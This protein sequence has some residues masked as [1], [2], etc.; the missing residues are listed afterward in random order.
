MASKTKSQKFELDG[1]PL[2]LD[3]VNTLDDRPMP[4]A[5]ELHETYEDL[6]QRSFQS[7]AL[8]HR[9]NSSRR[10]VARARPTAAWRSL[11]QARRLRE[12][13]FALFSGPPKSG[14]LITRELRRAY[15]SPLLRRSQGGGTLQFRDDVGALNGMFGAIVRSTAELLASEALSRFRV[16]TLQTCERLLLDES[17]NR[18][19]QW[20]NMAVCGN[21]A[22]AQHYY[23]RRKDGR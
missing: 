6:L 22:K 23:Q 20:C 7:G 9:S 16:C 5:K 21:H 10:G 1:G 14:A 13:L 3:F 18:P 15:R 17:R 8:P 19:L 4:S 11:D 12:I 2:C